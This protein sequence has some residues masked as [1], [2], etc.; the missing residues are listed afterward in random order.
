M[1]K[2]TRFDQETK[3]KQKP[4]VNGDGKK[5]KFEKRIK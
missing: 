4:E 1:R 2:F 5:Q 3:R